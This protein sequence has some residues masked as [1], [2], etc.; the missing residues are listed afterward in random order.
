MKC[1]GSRIYMIAV[2]L[3]FCATH[4]LVAQ[5]TEDIMSQLTNKQSSSV[6]QQ[7]VSVPSIN[8]QTGMVRTSDLLP[9][10]VD[11]YYPEQS[12]ILLDGNVDSSKYIVGP[13]D[14]LGIYLWG[15]IER[16]Y[17]IRVLPEGY[18]II[19]TV[20]S[21][22][23]N[24]DTIDEVREKIQA[25]IGKNYS[26]LEVSVFLI[27]PRRFRLSIS[28]VVYVPGMHEAN[29][30][31][32]VSD[33]MDR[34]GIIVPGAESVEDIIPQ[35]NDISS[36]SETEGSV[37]SG[38]GNMGQEPSSTPIT[39]RA[40]II[41]RS[42][43]NLLGRRDRSLINSSAESLSMFTLGE[44][45]GSSSRSIIIHRNGEEIYAD[46]L[47]FIKL[48]DMDANPYVNSGDH[49]EVPQYKGD[50]TVLGEVND[51]GIYEY[52]D[53]DRICDLIRFGG[54]ITSVADTSN[55]ELIR[56]EPDGLSFNRI[57]IDLY[58]AMYINPD[59]TLYRLLESDRLNVRRKF[60]YKVLY[61]VAIEG[62]V[63]TPGQYTIQKNVS[64]LTDLIK[65]AGGFTGNENLEEARLIRR[66]SF[67]AKDME[68]ERLKPL[69]V[70][71]RSAE[72]N[73]YV[74]SYQRTFEGSINIDFV[75]LFRDNDL[76]NDVILQ[77]GDTIY[78][79]LVREYVNVMGAV[80]DP[81]YIKVK[82][83]ADL[84]YYIE[85][86]GGYNWDAN[87]RERSVIKA[88]TAQRYK[89]RY[90]KVEIEGGDTIHIPSKPIRNF[91]SYFREYT[92][93][94]TS[95]ATIVLIGLQLSK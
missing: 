75:K 29:A 80:K 54:G 55:A 47:R 9:E 45:R 39:N 92:S 8:Q 3:M 57:P 91:W 33:L 87:K 62:E 35:T 36:P 89:T 10:G 84:K 5:S 77:E 50:I 67:A 26:G 32:R 40:G 56:F 59:K 44:K 58:D 79:P 7:N 24:G 88:K 83:G 71:E 43:S 20:G 51:Q 19:P 2:I 78:I 90:M 13:G 6:P 81:G 38:A 69:P 82:E 72:E 42:Q 93:Y 63:I 64:T 27:E 41:G 14:L 70:T 74:R 95:V 53:G 48:G 16:Y 49:I 22:N 85:K 17:Q 12:S 65:L 94:A 21:I 61:D 66:S 46:M 11:L 18:L 1:H 28:G 68:Y 73:D 37:S 34:A 25:G 60:E 30:F 76:S 86:A 31:E 23:V 15:E 4:L 52:K